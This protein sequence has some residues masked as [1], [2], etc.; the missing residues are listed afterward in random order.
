[1]HNCKFELKALCHI[2]ISFQ[3]IP[4]KLNLKHYVTT[5]I[6]PMYNWKIELETLCH[7]QT[8]SKG[9]T[10]RLCHILLCH[11]GSENDLETL[12]KSDTILKQCCGN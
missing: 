3:C 5:D 9:E 6:I 1:M 7:I 10:V 11:L 12:S 8:Y 4:G 2:Q